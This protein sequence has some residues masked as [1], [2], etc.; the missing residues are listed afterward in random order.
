[1]SWSDLIKIT[2]HM[3]VVSTHR[4]CTLLG[5]HQVSHRGPRNRP[6]RHSRHAP[7]R[8][9]LHFI[10]AY[11]HH[12]CS[13]TYPTRRKLWPRRW[14]VVEPRP[15]LEFHATPLPLATRATIDQLRLYIFAV[16]FFLTSPYRFL[17]F[18]ST[19]LLLLPDLARHIAFPLT[20]WCNKYTWDIKFCWVF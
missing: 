8:V 5:Q 9:L 18:V 17:N 19:L 11:S 15:R 3:H 12:L 2:L 7:M 14:R 4:R 16:S 13:P 10:L 20:Q 1:M 6:R